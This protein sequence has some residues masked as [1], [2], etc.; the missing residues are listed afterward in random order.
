MK[1]GLDQYTQRKLKEVEFR[2][3]VTDGYDRFAK[4]PDY[5]AERKVTHY[6]GIDRKTIPPPLTKVELRMKKEVEDKV[7]LLL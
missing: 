5:I 4:D 3:I 2:R 1:V 7:R 6:E